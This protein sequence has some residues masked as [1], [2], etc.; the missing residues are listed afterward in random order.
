MIRRLPTRPTYEVVPNAQLLVN[1]TCS[2]RD[3]EHRHVPG[4]LVREQLFEEDGAA[5]P[6]AVAQVGLV[7]WVG[8][9]VDSRYGVSGGNYGRDRYEA[10]VLWS[11]PS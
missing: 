1:E 9:W 3:W 4:D 11:P 6:P 10:G 5:A 7:I 2:Q 8:E